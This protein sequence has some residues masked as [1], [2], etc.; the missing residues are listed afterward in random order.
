MKAKSLLVNK[1]ILFLILIHIANYFEWYANN[2][3]RT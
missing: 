3:R 1:Q 2:V